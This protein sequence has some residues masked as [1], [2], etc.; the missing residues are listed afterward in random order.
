IT[1]VDHT[2]TPLEGVTFSL[3]GFGPWGRRLSVPA[4]IE[5]GGGV[6]D[7]I[8]RTSPLDRPGSYYVQARTNT[9]PV[10]VYE[11]Q[12]MVGRAPSA[13]GHTLKRI[14]R[15]VLARFGD[16]VAVKATATGTETLFIDG[17]TL[18]GEPS[19]FAGPEFLFPSAPNAGLMRYITA[20]SRNGSA[21]TP[22]R[23]LPLPTQEREEAHITNAHG[24]VVT[25]R[26]LREAMNF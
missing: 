22:N 20:F 3:V 19:R 12:W 26:A 1:V 9:D 6:Y 10:Q 17:G 25:F 24:I 2:G 21:I 18:V 16:L 23:P 13:T 11:S 7:V 5:R 4:P 15:M 8:F 14:R